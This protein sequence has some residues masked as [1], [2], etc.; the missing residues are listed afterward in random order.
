MI[1]TTRQKAKQ[2]TKQEKNDLNE[3]SRPEMATKKKIFQVM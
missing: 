3:R 1:F 2:K